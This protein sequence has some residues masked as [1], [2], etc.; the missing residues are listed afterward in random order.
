VSVAVTVSREFVEIWRTDDCA[1][2]ESVYLDSNGVVCTELVIWDRD[3]SR[4]REVIGSVDLSTTRRDWEAAAPGSGAVLVP[5]DAGRKVWQHLG[6]EPEPELAHNAPVETAP[7]AEPA[8]VTVSKDSQYEPYKP[9]RESELARR[10]AWG[11]GW[12]L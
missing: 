4:Y 10:M 3:G 6:P 9:P 1:A 7:V 12:D 2:Y 8:A 5:D 11:P